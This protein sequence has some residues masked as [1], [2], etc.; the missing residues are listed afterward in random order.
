MNCLNAT[1]LIPRE[2]TQLVEYGEILSLH[3]FTRARLHQSVSHFTKKKILLCS[4]Q[5]LFEQLGVQI[6]Y[7]K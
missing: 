6:Y 2:K 1:S 3:P 5:T 7:F 4:S